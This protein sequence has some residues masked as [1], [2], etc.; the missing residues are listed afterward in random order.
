MF[1]FRQKLRKKLEVYFRIT[2]I[3]ELQFRAHLDFKL[4]LKQMFIQTCHLSDEH[5]CCLGRARRLLSRVSQTHLKCME[6]LS[7]CFLCA[8]PLNSAQLM[9]K[10]SKSGKYPEINKHPFFMLI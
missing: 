7:L 9:R 3:L 1:K 2:T 8:F 5:F 10:V 4:L 6:V